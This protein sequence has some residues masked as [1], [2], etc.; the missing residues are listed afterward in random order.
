M[1]AGKAAE[2]D[3]K[4]RDGGEKREEE[5]CDLRGCSKLVEITSLEKFFQ[6]RIK[7]GES[8]TISRDKNKIT[9]TANSNLWVYVVSYLLWQGFSVD[10]GFRMRMYGCY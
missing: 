1:L 7:I 5:E 10:V 9:V 3:E 6:E 8:V 4:R 2:K